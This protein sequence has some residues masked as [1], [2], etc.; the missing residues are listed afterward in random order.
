MIN[1]VNDVSVLTNIPSKL[2]DKIKKCEEYSIVENITEL[3]L[4]KEKLNKEGLISEGKLYVNIKPTE[5]S[6]V[7]KTFVYEDIDVEG[8][9]E[10]ENSLENIFFDV[11]K[12]GKNNE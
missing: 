3:N 2:L 4:E 8:V 5:V 6:K 9:N 7:V 12:E 10:C 1:I 11:T